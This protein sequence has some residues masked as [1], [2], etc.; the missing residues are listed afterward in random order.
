MNT[1]AQDIAARRDERC[2]RRALRHRNASPYV[3]QIK[4]Q[5]DADIPR[6]LDVFASGAPEGWTELVRRAQ[7]HIKRMMLLDPAERRCDYTPW[8]RALAAVGAHH[9]D[10]MSFADT[11]GRPP[12]PY[13]RQHL[14]EFAL[15]FLEADLMLFRS[16][17]TKRHLLDRLRQSDLTIGQ[18]DRVVAILKRAVLEGSGLEEFRACC[19]TAAA[20]NPPGLAVWL[21]SIASAAKLDRGRHLHILDHRNLPAAY[22]EKGLAEWSDLVFFRPP[23]YAIPAD[24]CGPLVQM[25]PKDWADPQNRAA[26][27]AW[28]MLRAIERRS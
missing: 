28:R 12:W 24:L 26:V 25:T 23:K 17:Y 18:I 9:I 8:Q 10:L 3:R 27:N 5:S 4:E 15:T 14:I 11:A 6:R 21:R 19:R 22:G 20:L 13:D 2:L 1:S 16:G 7:D